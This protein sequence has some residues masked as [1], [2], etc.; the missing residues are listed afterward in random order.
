MGAL[1]IGALCVH[2]G[3]LARS[4]ERPPKVGGWLGRVNDRDKK[5]CQSKRG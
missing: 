2:Y 3:A 1:C 4:M 5:G